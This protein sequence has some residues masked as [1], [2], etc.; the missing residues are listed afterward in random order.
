MR[1]AIECLK[2]EPYTPTAKGPCLRAGRMVFH[3]PR[4]DILPYFSTVGFQPPERKN[5]ADF[6][7]EVSHTDMLSLS[8]SLPDECKHHWHMLS[9]QHSDGRCS[10]WSNLA[11]LR[12]CLVLQVCSPKDQ[13][14][15]C[16]LLGFSDHHKL[17]VGV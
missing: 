5:P 9:Y 16:G 4:Q 1:V 12:R 6:V 14:V 13:K 15:S 2:L 3:G 17:H 7:Q 10:A 11:R 8:G